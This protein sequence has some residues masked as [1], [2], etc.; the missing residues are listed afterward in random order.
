M[1]LLDHNGK[2]L[3]DHNRKS[4][5]HEMLTAAKWA[6]MLKECGKTKPFFDAFRPLLLDQYGRWLPRVGQQGKTIR[7]RRY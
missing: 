4:P 3:L 1:S 5:E 6:M 7:F 2:P